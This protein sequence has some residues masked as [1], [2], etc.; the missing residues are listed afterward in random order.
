MTQQSNGEDQ[1]DQPLSSFEDIAALFFAPV[2]VATAESVEQPLVKDVLK[3]AITLQERGKE[4]FAHLEEVIA[5]LRAEVEAEL[6][7]EQ[8]TSSQSENTAA[9]S[10]QTDS[11][12]AKTVL[13][14]MSEFD[15]RIR[16]ATKGTVDARS[17][18]PILF[19]G[20]ALR[21]LIFKGPQL[22][23]VPWYVLAWYSFDSFMKFHDR[24][25][26]LPKADATVTGEENGN[27]PTPVQDVQ[28]SQE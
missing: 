1:E 3:A 25:R 5:D 15:T 22:D 11:V 18:M 10:D 16:E 13:K 4:S 26:S 19:G 7:Q 8:E 12:L 14:G 23:D 21:Q 2:W 27:S 9:V 17:L 6:A 28:D 24:H 20:L